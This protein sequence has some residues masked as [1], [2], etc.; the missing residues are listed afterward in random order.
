MQG[1]CSATSWVM[2]QQQLCF[3]VQHADVVLALRCWVFPQLKY[4]HTVSGQ[5]HC[6]AVV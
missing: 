1:E 3:V 6:T 2:R 4:L 5:M